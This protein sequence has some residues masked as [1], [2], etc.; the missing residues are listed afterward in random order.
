MIKNRKYSPDAISP[1]TL[2]E[3]CEE[4]KIVKEQK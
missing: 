4:S 2:I 1:L 3:T